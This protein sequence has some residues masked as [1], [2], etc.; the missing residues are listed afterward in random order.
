[1]INISDEIPLPQDIHECVAP[2]LLNTGTLCFDASVAFI[3]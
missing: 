2:E 3:F 1:M